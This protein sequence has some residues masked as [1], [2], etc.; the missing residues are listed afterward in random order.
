MLFKQPKGLVLLFFTELWERFG[1]YTLQTVFVLYVSH[2]LHFSD[3]KAY[4]LLGAFSALQYITPVIGGHLADFYLGFQRTILIGGSLLAL[5]YLILVLPQLKFFLFGLCILILGNGFFKPNV[6]SIVGTLYGKDD[7][8]RDSGFTLFYMGIN[9]GSLIPP[10]FL[11]PLVKS[12]GWGSAF[13]LATLGM[14][15]STILFWWG[16]KYLKGRGDIPEHSFL[17]DKQKRAQFN[18]LLGFGLL[19]TIF[20]CALFLHLASYSNIL[21]IIASI[22]IV[23]WILRIILCLE[24]RE[25]QRMLV[26]LILVVISIGFWAIYV[27]SWSSLMLFADR[28]MSHNFIGLNIDAEFTQ[29]FNPFF[30]IVLSP[31]LSLLWPRLYK[32]GLNP[33]YPLKFALAIFAMGAGFLLLA[34]GIKWFSHNGLS[35]PWWLVWSYFLQTLGELVLSPIGLAMITVLTPQKYVGMMMGIWFLA[36]SA[37]FAVGSELATIADVPKQASILVS[38]HIYTKA[39]FDFAYLGFALS[40]IVLI[41]TPKLKRMLTL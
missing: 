17:H 37:A 29:A 33:S 23:L 34:V 25:Q 3:E 35:S 18:M 20:I 36:L 12:Y 2:A 28:N 15:I 9:I 10:L 1:Y 22:L 41:I 8:K 30:I 21:L 11:G 7:P 40:L 26:A 19:I 16:R 31:L 39:F 13:L 32:S 24:G 6:S 4:L 5:G 38:Q 14:L 27:Q